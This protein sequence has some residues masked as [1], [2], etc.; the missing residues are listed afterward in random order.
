MEE[1]WKN[2]RNYEGY[3]QAS[4]LGR[5]KSL[6]KYITAVHNS[7]RFVPGRVLKI[8]HRADYCYVSLY[9]KAVCEIL[10]VHSIVATIF[11]PNPKNKPEVNHK[12]FNKT[13][14][15][16]NNLEWCTK[17]E[18]R[19]HA[20]K[21]NRLPRGEAHVNSKLNDFKVRVIRR[22]NDLTPTEIGRVFGVGYGTISCVLARKTWN[23]L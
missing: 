11:I 1:I 2:V 7:V 21:H 19:A 13:N 9:V 22:C 10:S 3:Y 14:N 20:I 23:H 4:N 5:V 15:N 6:G 18:N 16:I 12:D 17:E 8:T